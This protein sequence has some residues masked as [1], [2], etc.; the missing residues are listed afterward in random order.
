METDADAYLHYPLHI[1]PTSK[2]ISLSPSSPP[3]PAVLTTLKSI[4]ALHT[5]LKTL[6]TPNSIPPAPQPSGPATLKLTQTMNKMRDAANQ[7]HRRGQHKIAVENYTFAI[8]MAANRPPWESIT[9]IRDELSGLYRDRAASHMETRAWVEAWK[10]CEASVECKRPQGLNVAGKPSP[11]VKGGKCL[12][13]L[14]R[15]TEAVGWLTRGIDCEAVSA[16]ILEGQAG[17]EEGK[18]LR[19]MLAEAERRAEEVKGV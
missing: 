5:S 16:Q 10:D 9:L 1:D 15:F 18:E 3:D 7:A 14:G 8:K 13:E 2:A 12:M 6:D 4:N 11:W 17:G 19:K